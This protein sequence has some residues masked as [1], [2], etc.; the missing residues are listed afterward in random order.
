MKTEKWLVPAIILLSISIAFSGLFISKSILALTESKKQVVTEQKCNEDILSFP[1]TAV[2]LKI[3]VDK[4]K[5]IVDNSKFID[6]KGI[7]YYKV[8]NNIMFSK[9]ALSEWI[10]N[11]SENRFD[12]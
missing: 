4:L 11:S 2:Y 7:P 10:V 12:Y 6:G 5:S 1:E 8:D 9:T 3:S